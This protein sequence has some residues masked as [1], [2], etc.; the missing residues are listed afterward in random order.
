MGFRSSVGRLR[1]AATVLWVD[2]ADDVG[3]VQWARKTGPN[4]G[5][6]R[7]GFTSSLS[8]W[9]SHIF[10]SGIKNQATLLLLINIY[11]IFSHPL[12]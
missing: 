2:A 4:Q 10:T 1:C 6:V 7:V 9:L 12:K 8:E 3:L 5:V 11:N